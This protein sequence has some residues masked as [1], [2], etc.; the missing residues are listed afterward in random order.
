MKKEE[1]DQLV[2][3]SFEKANGSKLWEMF[4]DNADN[5]ERELKKNQEKVSIFVILFAACMVTSQDIYMDTMREILYTLC[6]DSEE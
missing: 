3:D 2:S 6:C 5:L 1:I 4:I